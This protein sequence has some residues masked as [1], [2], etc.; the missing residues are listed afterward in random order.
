VPHPSALHTLNLSKVQI[1]VVSPASAHIRV[2][3]P[4]NVHTQCC[5]QQAHQS[6]VPR[7]HKHTYTL[8][9]VPSKPHACHATAGGTCQ[10]D[11][12][13]CTHAQIR[14]TQR[15]A[16]PCALANSMF[17]QLD[18][19]STQC[20]VDVYSLAKLL[21]STP[22]SSMGHWLMRARL[23]PRCKQSM[24]TA[25]VHTASSHAVSSQAAYQQPRAR[26]LACTCTTGATAKHAAAAGPDLLPTCRFSV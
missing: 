24:P 8:S 4:A 25:S 26:M 5:P 2:L 15:L 9:A 11:E 3:F 1:S 19:W 22:H 23:Q 12:V 13:A 17:G 20:L 14:G 10:V 18:V 21:L 6:A 16:W 7:K